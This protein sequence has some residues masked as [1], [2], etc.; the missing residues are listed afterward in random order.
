MPDKASEHLSLP[1]SHLRILRLLDV[2]FVTGK[3]RSTIYR[4]MHSGE[5]PCAIKIGARAVGWREVDI[6]AWIESRVK[7]IPQE[8][9]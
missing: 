1:S 5:F 6:A 3:S 8:V 9:A 7:D 4:E 2:Q